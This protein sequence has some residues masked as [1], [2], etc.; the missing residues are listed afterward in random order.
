MQGIQRFGNYFLLKKIATG[1][2]A[3]LFK[4]KKSGAEGF[5]KLLAI[6]LILPHLSGNEEFIS[7]FIDEAK[8][9]ALLNHQNIVQIYDLGRIENSYCIVMEYVRGKDLRTVLHRGMKTK[10]PLPVE[11]ACL[12][13]AQALAGL[14]Y[15]HRKKDKGKDLGIVHRD[16]SPQNILVSY[17]GEV[18]IVDFGIA[19]AATQSRDTRVGVLKG[20]ISYMSPEQA[21]GR[22]LDMRSDVFSTGVVFYEMLT[23]KK[24]F[25]GDTDLNT[26]EKVREAKVEPLPTELNG[27]VPKELEGIL[28]KSLAKE[29]EQRFQT[30]SEMEEALLAFM[31]KAGY[32]TSANSLSQQMC[33][34]FRQEIEDEAREEEGWDETIVSTQ[35]GLAVP[36]ASTV[37]AGT[38]PAAAR[39]TQATKPA[40][41][42]PKTTPSARTASIS[43]DRGTSGT[44]GWQ[45]ALVAILIVSAG[46]G[47]WLKFRQ[48][49][50]TQAMPAPA[51]ATQQQTPPPPVPAQ[52]KAVEAPVAAPE[53]APAPKP[54]P[55]KAA[56]APAPK[57]PEKAHATVTSDPDGADVFID[58]VKAGST[59]LSLD[60]IAPGSHQV[61]VSKDGYDAWTGSLEAQPG[62][63]ATVNASLTQQF[64]SFSIE[65]RPWFFVLIDGDNKGTTPLA[66]IKLAAGDHSLTLANPRLKIRKQV[67]LHIEPNKTTSII[68]NPK[69]DPPV[70]EI[71]R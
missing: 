8:V 28:L 22:P 1:G 14:S 2:M 36:A 68:I 6:K 24:L 16:I 60:S 33:G 12:I 3:E 31:R 70:K 65:S 30:A 69:A 20:K 32:S 42:K 13:T 39:P 18:K 25:Q 62:K 7:M 59:P 5:E 48:A 41:T 46:A 51:V 54:K 23:G 38:V 64:G 66:G 34:L 49:D 53:P 15:A 61:K 11:H 57:A 63:T 56:A 17:E 35:P 58:G 10:S 21:H 47:L 27:A 29:P 40:T 37:P 43:K 55:V 4:A 26:L 52:V 9:A 44:P 50:S 19:K 67:T 45:K 71:V